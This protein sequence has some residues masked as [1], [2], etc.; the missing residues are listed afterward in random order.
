MIWVIWNLGIEVAKSKNGIIITQQKYMLYL[1]KE[2]CKL[3]AKSVGSPIEL[4]HGLDHNSGDLLTN[5][6]SL[7]EIGWKAYLFDITR[8]D[9]CYVVSVVSQFMHVPRTSYLDAVH[10]ILKYLKCSPGQGILYACPGH[11]N[12]GIY[13]CR[14]GEVNKI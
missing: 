2:T 8:W 14:L 1:L 13:P 9:I 10:R 12:R 6:K 4:I 3:G 7:P 5:L 11:L